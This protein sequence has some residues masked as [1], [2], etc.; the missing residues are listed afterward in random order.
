MSELDTERRPR[1]NDAPDGARDGRRQESVHVEVRK[2]PG[3]GELPLPAYMSE[4]ASGLDLRA[5]VEDAL[6]LSPGEFKLVP[7][8]IAVAI[9][10][11][12]EGHRLW[13]VPNPSG[14]NAHE[15]VDTLAEAYAA[16]ARAA[17]VI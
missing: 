6:V 13:V 4:G 2:L 12:F 9:P 15:T 11:G 7:T 3:L 1:R 8:G 5:A 17:G 14:L 10:D 16:P